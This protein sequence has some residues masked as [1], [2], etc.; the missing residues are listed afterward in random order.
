MVAEMTY[1]DHN[2]TTPMRPEAVVAVSEVMKLTGANPSSVHRLG[3]SSRSR[4]ENARDAVSSLVN[5]RADEVIFTGSGSEADNMVIMGG[6]WDRVFV[7]ETEHSAV[8][9][10]ALLRS[11]TSQLL[12]VDKNGVIDLDVLNKYLAEGSGSAL[13]CVMAANNETGVLQP[14]EDVVKIAQAHG[15][16]TL[17]DSV[18]AAGKINVDFTDAR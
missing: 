15:A 7:A 3:R 17:C 2:A 13:V 11:G 1:L 18:Q 12:P 14:I 8:L 6:G 10:T 5:A 16:Q 4:V 9:K